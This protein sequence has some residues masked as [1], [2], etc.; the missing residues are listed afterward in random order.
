MA[1]REIMMTSIERESGSK[2]ARYTYHRRLELLQEV[3]GVVL[4]CLRL[5]R[6]QTYA[7]IDQSHCAPANQPVY[8]VVAY[9]LTEFRTRYT[10]VYS[11]VLN[12][13]ESKARALLCHTSIATTGG[14]LDLPLTEQQ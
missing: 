3:P 12:Q 6:E 14:A 5:G 2:R 10:V 9:A 4:L 13:R 11:R 1:E 7:L 8:K